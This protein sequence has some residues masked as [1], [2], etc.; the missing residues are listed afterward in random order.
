[1]PGRS[2]TWVMS[3]SR[4]PDSNMVKPL[5]LKVVSWEA[6][7]GLQIILLFVLVVLKEGGH[8]NV[9]VKLPQF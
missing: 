4:R 7:L 6:G 9:D 3:A 5:G 2:D 1:M 8:L